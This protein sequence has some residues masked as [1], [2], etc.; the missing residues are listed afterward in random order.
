M[1]PSINPAVPAV[2]NQE[3]FDGSQPPPQEEVVKSVEDDAEV[4]Q[5]FS[6][7]KSAV[8]GASILFFCGMTYLPI[9][10]TLQSLEELAD[11]D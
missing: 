2:Y 1:T 7:A 6:L 10:T 9:L 8:I 4:P 3:Q 5:L 11:L